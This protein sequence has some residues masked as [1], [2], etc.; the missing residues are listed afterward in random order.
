MFGNANERQVRRMAPMVQR[1][2]ALEP[3]YEK[4]SDV[5]LK[6]TTLKLRARRKAVPRLMS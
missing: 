5:E 6:E 1:I 2:N 3:Q 4:L